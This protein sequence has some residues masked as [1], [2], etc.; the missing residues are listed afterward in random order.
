MMILNFTLS[1]KYFTQSSS[2]AF[3]EA[4]DLM[5]LNTSNLKQF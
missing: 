3:K 4:T 1:F 2:R 5:N